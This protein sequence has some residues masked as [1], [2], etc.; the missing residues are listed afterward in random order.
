MG[1]WCRCGGGNWNVDATFSIDIL[2][3]VSVRKIT[4]MSILKLTIIALAFINATSAIANEWSKENTRNEIVYQTLAMVDWAQTINIAHNPNRW[5]EQNILF[6]AHP[7][8]SHVNQ[9]FIVTG[10]LQFTVA[11]FMPAK[12]RSIFQYVTIGIE[13]G[14]VINNF[15]VGINAKF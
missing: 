2:Y 8:V 3:R 4:A 7:A 6:V 9:Y 12:Y 1:Q 15:S 14:A 5:S 11:Y 13:T 10:A